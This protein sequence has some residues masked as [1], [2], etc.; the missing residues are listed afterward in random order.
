LV[1]VG[2]DLISGFAIEMFSIALGIS[3]GVYG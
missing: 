2:R 3:A 1:L